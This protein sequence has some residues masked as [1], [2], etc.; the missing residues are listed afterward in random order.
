ME[1]YIGIDIGGTSIKYGV[2]DESGN[3]LEKLNIDTEAEKG[4]GE[5]LKK[6]VRIVNT[7]IEAYPL[8]GVCISTA[9]MVDC[10]KGEIFFSGDLIP[11]YTGVK[12]KKV[13]EETFG[14]PC[15][16]EN[17]VNCAGLAEYK[18]GAAQGSRAALCLT[19]GT[20]I[21]GSAVIGGEVFHGG[22]NS[23]MEIGYLPMGDSD[24]QTLG[25]ASI[26]SKKVALEK[27]G[28]PEEWN[29]VRIFEHAKAGDEVCIRA[30]DEMCDILGKGIAEICYVL[31]PDVVVLGGGIMAQKEVLRPRIT[32]ALQ[33]YLKPV[34]FE[35][36]RLEFAFHKNDAGMLGA[37]YHFK[38]R[39]DTA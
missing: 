30:I 29:G 39:H 14:I 4:G 20:G 11:G 12:L 1:R 8:S 35:H 7:Y 34:I 5:I 18:T 25:A 13:V 16:V 33:K 28:T 17:D 38:S 3:I 9:G 36:T 26:L 37:F 2:L 23:A 27:N 19:I 24:F 31:N 6:V 21:G 15:E 10:E 32:R 22:S